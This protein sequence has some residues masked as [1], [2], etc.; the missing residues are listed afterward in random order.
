ML[1]KR[2]LLAV[3]VLIFL[4]VTL[5][6]VATGYLT[7]DTGNAS[8]GVS[9]VRRW[10]LPLAAVILLLIVGLM[11]WQ[12]MV[13]DRLVSPARVVWE[14]DR[15]P[16]PG[17]E[18]FTERDAAVFFGRDVEVAEL[19]ERLHP[20]VP[21]QANRL[22]AVVGPSGVGKS[23]LIQAGV[24]PRLRQRRGGWV[25]L[26][27]VVPG[28]HPL[29]SLARAL[30]VAGVGHGVEKVHAGLVAGVAYLPR[31]VDE[32]RAAHG[33]ATAPAL[34]IVDQAEELVTL[35]GE[36][37]REG[38]LTQLADALAADPRLW[39]ILIMRSEF[40]TAFLGTQQAR[41]FRDPVAVGALSNAAL[42]EVIE[43]PA[44]CA[45]LR[46]EPPTLTQTIAGDAGGGDALPLLA[47]ALEELY[48]AA[49]RAKT[50]TAGS[51]HHIGGVTGVL[52]RQADKV[53]AELR[54]T[55]GAAPVLPTLLKFVTVRDN[56]PT[57]RRVLRSALTAAEW[58]VVEALISARLLTSRV[59]GDDAVVDVAHEALFRSWTPLRQAIEVCAEQLRWRADLERWALDWEASGRQDAYLLRG[60]RLKAAQRW[61]VGET[62]EV[63]V[64]A[65]VAEF[66]A[67]SNLADHATM[68]RLSESIARQA[69]GHIDRDPDY[70]LLL[71]LGAHEECARTPLALRALTAALVASQVRVVL[72][73]HTDNV[74]D[75]AW[76]PD[77]LLLA[78]ASGDRTARIWNSVGGGE[79]AVLRGHQDWVAGVAWS[80][81]R[82]RLATASYD[83]TFRIWDAATWAEL[84]AV[85]AHD[86]T[87]RRIAWSPDGRRLATA[88]DDQTARIWDVDG[89]EL[90]VLAGHLSWV[91]GV[92]WSPDG[93]WLATAAGDRTA[94]IWNTDGAIHAELCGHDGELRRVAWSPDGR[95]L[96][97]ASEDRTARIWST[98]GDQLA[99]LRGHKGWVRGV[100]WS[101]D[102]RQLATGSSDRTVRVWDADTGAE[103]AVLYGHRGYVPAVAWSPQGRRLA[104]GSTD[105]TARIWDT[106]GSSESVI[107]YGHDGWVRGVAWSPDSLRLATASVDQ[108]SRIWDA[109]T[110]AELLL[111]R[112]HTGSIRSAAWSIDGLRLATASFDRTVRI[113]DTNEGTELV[114]LNG[115]DDEV[116]AVI[117]SPD[118]HTL[119]TGSADRT[120]RVWDAKRGRALVVLTG[121]DDDV[122]GTSW[123]PDARR[124]ATASDDQTARIWDVET[125]AELAVLQGHTG[126]IRAMAWSPDGRWLATGSADNSTRLWDTR[127]GR[128]HAVLRGHD[129]W[130]QGVAWSPD[131]R[132]LVTGSADCTVRIWDPGSGEELIVVGA[133]TLAVESV[134][135]SPDGRRIASS[136]QDGTGR[137]WDATISIDELVANAH[138]R[139]TRELTAEER[140][141]LMLP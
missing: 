23:S 132:R 108:T 87:L 14:S 96:A 81:D 47:Y 129:D 97:T 72:R 63:A 65:P 140:R 49:G 104:S 83:G 45:G 70:G 67:S 61:A 127:D 124:L 66:V 82:R 93:Q 41:L 29:R 2:P 85:R 30:A 86:D 17:L 90:A 107:L 15:S 75:V 139:V 4:L 68:R 36:A 134:S 100:A 115:H 1:R 128:Q 13:E 95:R 37:E 60:A 55:D 32:L 103:L 50:V 121:H 43:R 25:V 84:M 116:K 135:W 111:L 78:T 10:S 16:Y 33:R 21:A 46:F 71:A 112:G 101:S 39:V 141:N 137:V 52:T 126:W 28:D 79:V 8:Q 120:V 89:G 131:A 77:G 130:V 27:Q 98:N 59:Q 80:P 3:Q 76:S 31:L 53:V 62:E 123:S 118:G 69:L 38:F 12:H 125:G 74:T 18:A 110:G 6:G 40:L 24:L 56:E 35:S 99:V 73:G 117:W 5:L 91:N 109:T 106:V 22:V 26:P 42:V 113:W 57:R 11:V 94:R 58:R 48:L 34:L 105:R 102:A 19:L 138:R 64:P 119:A 7:N 51:Y 54:S 44:R 122:W 136:S 133:H 114:V 92:A 20:V 9:V 88:S